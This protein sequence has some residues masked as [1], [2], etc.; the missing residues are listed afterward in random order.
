MITEILLPGPGKRSALWSELV[1]Q[2]EDYFERVE[3]CPLHPSSIRLNCKRYSTPFRSIIPAR[4]SADRRAPALHAGVKEASS[5]H[6]SPLLFRLVHSGSDIHGNSW[7]IAIGFGWY[8]GR[9]VSLSPFGRTLVSAAVILLLTIANSAGL[10]FG[11]TIQNVFALAKVG[12]LV[13]MVL[14][15]FAHPRPNWIPRR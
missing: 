12:G 2:A 15:L 5:S 6:S 4:G 10:R 1:A 13:W 3:S 7:G 11:K 9:L 8:M 14:V